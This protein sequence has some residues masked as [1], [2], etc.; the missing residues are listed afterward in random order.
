MIV[1]WN[2]LST[3]KARWPHDPSYLAGALYA[4]H[5]AVSQSDINVAL[6]P[7]SYTIRSGPPPIDHIVAAVAT[8]MLGY[9]INERLTSARVKLFAL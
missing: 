5:A 8:N 4:L 7:P 9:E 2:A 1:D 3:I 6:R